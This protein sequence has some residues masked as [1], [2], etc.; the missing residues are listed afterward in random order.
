MLQ[1]TLA[2]LHHQIRFRQCTVSHYRKS[3]YIY[4][5]SIPDWLGR[6]FSV[7]IRLGQHI[8]S[9]AAAQLIHTGITQ[10]EILDHWAIHGNCSSQLNCRCQG[11]CRK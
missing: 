3:L 9:Q 4:I 1:F 11:C 6:R 8:I 2:P 10:T 5:L 7:P